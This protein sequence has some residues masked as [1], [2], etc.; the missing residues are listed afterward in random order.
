LHVSQ[1]NLRSA[2]GI[3]L[4]D[5]ICVKMGLVWNR[6]TF[7]RFHLPCN[8]LL[9]IRSLRWC[10][11]QKRI[12]RVCSV[13]RGNH[14]S[15]A[16]RGFLSSVRLSG[17]NV[18]SQSRAGARGHGGVGTDSYMGTTLHRLIWEKATRRSF[19][20]VIL[21]LNGALSPAGGRNTRAAPKTHT[22]HT[23][24]IGGSLQSSS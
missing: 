22:K 5:H 13:H 14:Y 9:S 6:M 21:L 23:D 2:H 17:V 15:M 24:L 4:L 11:A 12:A 1:R 8:R 20:Q 18:D 7:V 10:H 3:G 19:A 16:R